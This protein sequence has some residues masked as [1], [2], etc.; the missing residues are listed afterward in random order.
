MKEARYYTPLADKK[1]KCDLC[2][3]NCV[4]KDGQT[5]I[6]RTRRNE[7]GKL[8]TLAYA[9]PCAINL[10]PVE[11]KPLFHF[12]PGH[13]TLSIATAGCNLRCLH[14]QNAT[15]S[16]V[17][18]EEV[19][20]MPYDPID[21]VK[22]AKK[23]NILSIS[24]TYTEPIVF[25]E[26]VLDTAKLA[27]KNGLKNIIVS[28]GYINP[29]PLQELSQYIDAANIDLKSFDD[30]HYR[31][32]NSARLEPVLQTLKILKQNNVWLEITNLIIPGYN[33]SD[34]NF[35][36]MTQWLAQNG[37]ADTPLHFSRFYP[38]YKLNDAPPTPVE[39]IERAV[40]IARK[41]GILYVYG[42]NIAGHNSENTYCPQCGKVLIERTGFIST[43]KK[44]FKDGKCTKC[45]KEIAGVWE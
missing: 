16:Q 42:G 1:V 12:L 17:S 15:I 38:T 9:N 36:K 27:R 41:N 35:E 22:V 29:E 7:N 19:V 4:L 40:E 31:K 28:A 18:P 13:T 21:V 37:F 44:T 6:C 3:H 45:G 8:Y 20:N 11:K 25:Y 39:T 34:E 23:N 32:V 24:Y 26:Y 33:D 5:G 43:I 14:C 2:P 30:N 10:D